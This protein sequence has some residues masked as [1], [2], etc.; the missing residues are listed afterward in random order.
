MNR[1]FSIAIILLCGIS[2]SVIDSHKT[3][4][5][6]RQNEVIENILSESLAN[7]QSGY[8]QKMLEAA[9]YKLRVKTLESIANAVSFCCYP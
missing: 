9:E 4:T 3:L 7:Y 1:L 6:K 8:Y 5:D 2:C